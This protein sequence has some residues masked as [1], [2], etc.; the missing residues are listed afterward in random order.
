LDNKVFDI[1]DT[2][3]NHEDTHSLDILFGGTIRS[4]LFL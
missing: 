4:V 3:C 1:I 2:R